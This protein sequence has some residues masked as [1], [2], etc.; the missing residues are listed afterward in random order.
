MCQVDQTLYEYF[1]RKLSKFHNVRQEWFGGR[2][3]M[4]AEGQTKAILENGW[5]INDTVEES[6]NTEHCTYQ[7]GTQID[8][9]VKWTTG[10]ENIK[11]FWRGSKENISCFVCL[12]TVL[13]EVLLRRSGGKG[14][15]ILQD[16][17]RKWQ[18]SYR[19]KQLKVWERRIGLT[20]MVQTI[21]SASISTVASGW[22]IT[23]L[24]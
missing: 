15:L 1:S 18:S 17:S 19:P 24:S 2:W 3:N 14:L 4:S 7:R 16:R 20:A 8:K 9:N 12:Y 21:V 6:G 23:V 13:R 5:F 22:I 10:L 11:S